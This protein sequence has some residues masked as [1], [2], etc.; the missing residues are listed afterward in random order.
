[1][2]GSLQAAGDVVTREEGN[3]KWGESGYNEAKNF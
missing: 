3:V 1:M 2:E